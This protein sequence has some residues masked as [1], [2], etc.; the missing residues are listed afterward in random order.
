MADG[1]ERAPTWKLVL[2][3]ILDFFMVF[4]AGGY[5][6]A[7]VTGMRT[8]GGFN[9]TGWPALLLFALIVAYFIVGRRYAGG[10]MWDRF[11]G[12]SRPQPK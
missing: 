2:A 1:L 11:F 7:S 8:P 5:V 12:I 9:L 3:P 6:I 4:F 10:T